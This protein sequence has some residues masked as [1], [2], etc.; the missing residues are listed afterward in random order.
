MSLRCMLLRSL[1][2]TRPPASWPGQC[3]ISTRWGNHPSYPPIRPGTG[4]GATHTRPWS[5]GR[6]GATGSSLSPMGCCIQQVTRPFR[7]PDPVLNDG[8]KVGNGYRKVKPSEMREPVPMAN[9]TKL[10][11]TLTMCKKMLLLDSYRP[12]THKSL[13]PLEKRRR[14]DGGSGGMGSGN[15][16]SLVIR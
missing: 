15:R 9:V 10:L 1:L 16:L 5:T 14:G 11:Q 7:W 6:A 4:M 2:M 3:V 12:L 8:C 13:S